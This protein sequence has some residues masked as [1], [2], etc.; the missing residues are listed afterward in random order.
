MNIEDKMPEKDNI[1]ELV[2]FE[3]LD[4]EDKAIIDLELRL[5]A[6][7]AACVI[8]YGIDEIEDYMKPILSQANLNLAVTQ[9]NIVE[10]LI[11]V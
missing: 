11:S 3:N 9:R 5:S 2:D 7:S 4:N 10:E 1:I 6:I 8:E